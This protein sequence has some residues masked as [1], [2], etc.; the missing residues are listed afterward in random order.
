MAITGAFAYDEGPGALPLLRGLGGT[1]AECFLTFIK[2]IL[3]YKIVTYT[4]FAEF[5]N[6]VTARIT[7]INKIAVLKSMKLWIDY[8]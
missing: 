1:E 5:K 7:Q 8:K 3:T 6:T 4:F 2:R